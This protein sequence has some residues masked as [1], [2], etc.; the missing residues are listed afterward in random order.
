MDGVA[1][2]NSSQPPGKLNV[3]CHQ[4]TLFQRV[5]WPLKV[6]EVP[7]SVVSRIDSIANRKWLGLFRFFPDTGFS[8]KKAL[9][10]PLK[11]IKL[12]HKQEKVWLVCKLKNGRALIVHK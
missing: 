12:R 3:W 5:M 4:F 10:L 8:G 9:Q 2:I 7:S 6:S 11:S 1:R